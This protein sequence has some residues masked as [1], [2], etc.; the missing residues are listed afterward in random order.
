MLEI[1]FASSLGTNDRALHV[2]LWI[3][4]SWN[5]LINDDVHT[6]AGA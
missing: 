2:V 3:C 4:L 6:L 1:C 5:W